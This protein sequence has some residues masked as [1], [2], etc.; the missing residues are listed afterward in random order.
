VGVVLSLIL[1]KRAAAP[2]EP[3]PALSLGNPVELGHAVLLAALFGVVLLI[4]RVAQAELGTAGLWTV[5][6]VGGLVDV[7]SVAVAA[8]RLRQQDVVTISVASGAYLLATL[9]NLVFKSTVTVLTGGRALARHVLPA[10][11]IL[12]LLTVA[13]VL[14]SR[15]S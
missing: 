4:A 10:F 14:L 7:D 13:G 11:G 1:L 15:N 2:R 6:T 3:G 5:G 12:A 8:A 9:S